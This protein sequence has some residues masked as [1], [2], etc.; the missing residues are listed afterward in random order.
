MIRS[1]I[2][3]STIMMSSTMGFAQ[4][5]AQAPEMTEAEMEQAYLAIR[6]Q[7]GILKH[8]EEQGFVGAEAV[9]AQLDVL[10]TLPDGD[11]EAGEAAE[12][13]GLD[14][15]IDMPGQEMSLEDFAAQQGGTAEG[16]CQAVG[17]A[18][19]QHTPQQ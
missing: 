10:A 16:V 12:Q 8:C 11:V 14:G 6:N 2:V 18:V 3:A 17:D 9:A 19:M 15:T 13:R 1:I 5:A 7:L 4:E